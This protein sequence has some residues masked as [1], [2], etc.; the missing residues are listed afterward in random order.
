MSTVICNALYCLIT[1]PD[2]QEKLYKSLIE[3]FPNKQ[4]TY[5]SLQDAPLLKATLMESL[6]LLP[7]MHLNMRLEALRKDRNLEGFLG[8]PS[9]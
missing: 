8:R 4:I 5:E 9:A 2:S 1:N 6:R 3:A 7:T